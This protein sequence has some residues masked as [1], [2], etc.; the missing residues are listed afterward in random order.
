MKPEENRP[1]EHMLNV[2]ITD[3]VAE[4]IYSN[5]AIISHTAA[6]F[7]LDFVQV[8]PGVPKAR[9][10]SRIILSPSHFKRLVIAMQDNLH[11]YESRF[12]PIE[13]RDE[14]FPPVAFGGPGLA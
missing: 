13:I 12:G 8:F 3:E 2:E 6:E 5:L 9:V 4:G 7:I 1:D 10:R 14:N 11:K